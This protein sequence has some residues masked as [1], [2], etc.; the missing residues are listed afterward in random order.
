MLNVL[1]KLH[2][3]SNTARPA[4]LTCT[5]T[6]VLP[7]AAPSSLPSLPCLSSLHFPS[8]PSNEAHCKQPTTHSQPPQ[9]C[10]EP[11]QTQQSS[12]GTAT[13][14][15]TRK[16]CAL[17]GPFRT[18]R[19]LQL[20]TTCSHAGQVLSLCNQYWTERHTKPPTTLTCWPED[21]HPANLKH[22]P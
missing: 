12:P 19:L 8:L 4:A 20:A 21:R 3:S 18:G 1:C 10:A 13:L 7:T 16:H 5:M 9:S 22:Y 15:H 2:L 6:P 17:E 11:P 14:A